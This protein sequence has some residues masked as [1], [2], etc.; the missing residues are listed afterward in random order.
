MANVLD[1]RR[2]IRSV[3]NTR[4]ITK[5]MKMVSAARLRRAQDRAMTA[6][7]YAQ[8]LTSVLESLVRRTDM[9]NEQTGEILHPLLLERE[10]KNVLVVFVAGDKGFAG[11]FNSNIVKAGQAFIRERIDQGKT[12]DMELI[13]RKAVAHVGKR[14][15]MAVYEKKTEHYDNEL[16]THYEIVRHRSEPIE[17]AATHPD[18]LHKVEIDEAGKIA[19]SIIERYTRAEIDSV[20]L[21]Y[22]EFKSVIAQRVV[23][24]KLLPIRK[25]GSHEITAAEEMTEEQKEAAAKAAATAGVS[26]YEPEESVIEV[27]ARKFGTA[28]VDYILDQHPE[29]LFRH[30]MPRYVTTQIFHALLESTASEHAARMTAMDAA[31][32]N[33]GDMIDAYTLQMNRVRQAAITKEIIEIVS[34]AAA[35]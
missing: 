7:P 20:Y 2:R 3:K 25:L 33:A 8:M 26:L 30:L 16:A 23:V 15:P 34:G 19:Q 35:L 1:L 27:E 14:F 4:Q 31:T 24:E 17:V 10:E 9:Y 5:A 29:R 22:N 6:R 12:V 32:N 11:A 28:E 21:V 13:G 18:L